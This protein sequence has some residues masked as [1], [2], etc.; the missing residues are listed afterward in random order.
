LVHGEALVEAKFD[1]LMVIATSTLF[2]G[3]T[4]VCFRSDPHFPPGSFVGKVEVSLEEGNGAKLQDVEAIEF[5]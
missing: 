3:H 5:L 4:M 2:F 1:C